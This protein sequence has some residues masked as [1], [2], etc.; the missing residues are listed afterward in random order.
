MSRFNVKNKFSGGIL[1]AVLLGALIALPAFGTLDSVAELFQAAHYDD[2]LLALEQGDEGLRAGEGSLWQAR[3]TADPAKALLILREGLSDKRLPEQV[4][5]RMILETADIEFGLGH[6]QSTLKALAPLLNNDMAEVPGEAHLKAGLSL[7]ALNRLQKAREMLA[8]VKPQ[9]PAFPAARYYLGDI[10][11][12]Q[13]DPGLAL[14]YFETAAAGSGSGSHY[15]VAGGRWRA[16]VGEGRKDEAADLAKRLA[17]DA[18][19]SLAMLEIQR[20]RRSHQEE[21][22]AMAMEE[23]SE[24]ESGQ[25]RAS[26]GRYALQLGAFSDRG[27][28]LAFMRRFRGQLPD[29]RLDEVRDDRG[30]FL[31]KVRTGSFVNPALARTEAKRLA[32]QLDIEVIVAD[33]SENGQGVD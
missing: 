11:L 32:R 6:Y 1:R 13:D 19:G 16:L 22:D 7:R 24:A 33:L 15:R 14:R 31:Y 29:V 18:P 28:A 12:E 10:A 17:E 8:S 26:R 2:A 30:Q 9:D 25:D 5:T 21:L 23:T 20:I 4:K 3:L 27:L